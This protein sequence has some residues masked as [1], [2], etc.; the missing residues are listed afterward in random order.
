MAADSTYPFFHG[1]RAGTR[2]SHEFKNLIEPTCDF[3]G[4]HEYD[5]AHYKC[6]PFQLSLKSSMLTTAE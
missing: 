4:L 2:D 1:T 5:G 6:D 3:R